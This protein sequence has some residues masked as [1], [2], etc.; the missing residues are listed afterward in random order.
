M[1]GGV[2]LD[3]AVDTA[4]SEVDFSFLGVLRQRGHNEGGTNEEIRWTAQAKK[5][6]QI[7]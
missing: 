3:E 4:C 1:N 5:L 7:G 6:L 2:K